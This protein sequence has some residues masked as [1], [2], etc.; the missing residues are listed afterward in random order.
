MNRYPVWKYA[1]ILIAL[2]V[3]A[4]YTLPNFFGES[5][6]VQVSAAKTAVHVDAAVADKVE[7]LLK[8]AAITPNALTRD[9]GSIKA[10][11]DS[12]DVQLKAKDVLEK[13]LN[14]DPANPSY[15]V[16]LNLLSRSPA[17][18][19]ALRAEPMHLG[20]D[21]RG[22]VHFMLQV[23]MQAALTQR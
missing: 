11:F 2:L 8:A 13:G 16:A 21:L 17:W 22:G 19:G 23:D 9:A 14:A 20:L 1:I 6:A 4:I 7:A 10:R 18:L 12:P 3:G 5:P 15:I